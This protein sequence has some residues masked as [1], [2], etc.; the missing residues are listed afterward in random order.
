M[1]F[2]AQTQWEDSLHMHGLCSCQ[3][4]LAFGQQI[5]AS[6][7]FFRLQYF[8]LTTPTLSQTSKPLEMADATMA[9]SNVVD[10][11]NEMSTARLL[12]EAAK[13]A[14]T[15]KD[16]IERNEVTQVPM[17][18]RALEAQDTACVAFK[19]ATKIAQNAMHKA[20]MTQ[21]EWDHAK[22]RINQLETK[23][24]LMHALSDSILALPCV[25]F[26]KATFEAHVDALWGAKNADIRN[27]IDRN[28]Q[29]IKE[30]EEAAAKGV[31]MQS[32]G[33]QIE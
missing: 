20:E 18:L 7:T 19:M 27:L 25:S 22:A 26:R 2:V 30:F 28:E 23:G 11:P 33:N 14:V 17:L 10:D 9:D 31:K 24:E 13:V 29:L 15:F 21:H 8:V 4:R 16:Y 5:A 12:R 1:I 6:L 3:I 32:S